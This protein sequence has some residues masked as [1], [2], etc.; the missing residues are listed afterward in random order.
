MLASMLLG[1]DTPPTSIEAEL[2]KA[3]I[4]KNDSVGGIETMKEQMAAVNAVSIPSQVNMLKEMLE[5]Y[6]PPAE[7][8]KRITEVYTRQDTDNILSV[9]NDNLP[10][11]VNFDKKIRS[12]R[13]YVMA[14]RIDVILRKESP[15]IAVGGGHLGNEDGLISLLQ[16]K[17]YKLKNIP[18]TIKKLQ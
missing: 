17:G 10:V 1:G 7:I 3:A 12:D 16:K 11:D 2:Y 18:F 4:A 5:N 6:M 13:N 15:L 9:L 14:D 8:L